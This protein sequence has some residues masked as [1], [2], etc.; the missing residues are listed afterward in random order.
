MPSRSLPR[1]IAGRLKRMVVP[2]ALIPD[3]TDVTEHG[4]YDAAHAGS[5]DES[6]AETAETAPEPL[7][8]PQL[9]DI[10]APPTL[11]DADP[12]AEFEEIG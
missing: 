2:P 9:I 4:G 8:P 3:E 7:A 6:S 10:D 12:Q 11:V 1:R 5:P